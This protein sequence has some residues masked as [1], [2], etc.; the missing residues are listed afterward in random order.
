MIYFTL[1]AE[2][3]GRRVKVGWHNGRLFGDWSAVGAIASLASSLEGMPVVSAGK[4]ARVTWEDHLVD[5]HSAFALMVMVLG[6][7]AR[8]VA[9]KLPAPPEDVAS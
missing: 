6:T 3:H 5:P 7:D 8:L 2:Y 4:L 9:G 1:A